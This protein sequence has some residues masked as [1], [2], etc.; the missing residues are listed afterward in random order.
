MKKKDWI[1]GSTII[2]VMLL[3][4]IAEL[5]M[6]LTVILSLA[7]GGITALIVQAVID[8]K[9]NKAW[10]ALPLEVRKASEQIQQISGKITSKELDRLGISLVI[11]SDDKADSPK[12][13]FYRYNER[14]Y[15]IQND[16]TVWTNI[17]S[18]SVKDAINDELVY[19]PSD[20]RFTAVTVGGVTTGGFSEYG[21]FYTK[22][23]TNTGKGYVSCHLGSLSMP[24][25][26]MKTNSAL[27][28]HIK[29]DKVFSSLSKH[30]NGNIVFL[31]NPGDAYQNE[32]YL[33]AKSDNLQ[34]Y[35]LYQNKV[36]E[37]S[38]LE[39]SECDYLV[40]WFVSFAFLHDQDKAINTDNDEED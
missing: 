22:K 5:P 9:K 37:L 10:E 23:Y 4:V 32:L 29:K 6:F 17:P 1:W 16:G 33:A 27:N 26:Q 36:L 2:L 38:Y 19:H 34:A 15:T 31:H 18:F 20:I 3:G 40:N 7:A 21:D 39:K 30:K 14:I 8:Q 25:L 28:K 12:L 11:F 35:Q 13:Y 24:V